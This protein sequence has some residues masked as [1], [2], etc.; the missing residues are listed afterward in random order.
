MYAFLSHLRP[1]S[2][3]IVIRRSPSLQHKKNAYKSC[4]LVTGMYYITHIDEKN[5]NHKY[6]HGFRSHKFVIIR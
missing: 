4:N 3:G 2:L 1:E 6:I 5:K